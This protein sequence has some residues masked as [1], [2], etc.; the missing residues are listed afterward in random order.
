MNGTLS[1][2]PVQYQLSHIKITS[3]YSNKHEVLMDTD[4]N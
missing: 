2:L 4:G 3:K 1:K